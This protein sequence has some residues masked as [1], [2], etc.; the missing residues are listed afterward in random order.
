MEEQHLQQLHQLQLDTSG[1]LQLEEVHGVISEVPLHKLIRLPII[2]QSKLVLKELHL[3][4]MI[5]ME[6]GFSMNQSRAQ[7]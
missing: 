7:E 1:N 4:F 3:H 5:Q 6:M 2:L